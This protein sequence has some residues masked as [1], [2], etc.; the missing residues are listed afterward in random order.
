MLQFTPQTW[1]AFQ[2]SKK[3]EKSQF[4]TAFEE[5]QKIQPV[6]PDQFV[7]EMAHRFPQYDTK[8]LRQIALHWAKRYNE[9]KFKA[10]G[11]I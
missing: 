11:L 4:N 9:D 2:N 1:I 10:Q 3:V 5:A 6:T 7:E 8:Q